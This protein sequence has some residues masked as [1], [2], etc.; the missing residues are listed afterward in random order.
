MAV[1]KSGWMQLCKTCHM[2]IYWSWRRGT[3]CPSRSLARAEAANQPTFPRGFSA[4]QKQSPKRDTI[5]KY[6]FV[7]VSA[8]VWSL[9][10]RMCI[11]FY[12]YSY[13]ESFSPQVGWLVCVCLNI[14]SFLLLSWR[15]NSAAAGLRTVRI[16][17]VPKNYTSWGWWQRRC[18]R[19]IQKRRRRKKMCDV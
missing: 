19:I 18:E 14:H 2:Y 5:L 9:L 15:E 13:L 12:V 11:I 17:I 16:R 3:L 6:W 8:S 7:D 4:V 10:A 1:R